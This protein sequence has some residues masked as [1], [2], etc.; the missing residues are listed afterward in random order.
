[1]ATRYHNVSIDYPSRIIDVPKSRFIT[2]DK[3][4]AKVI[5]IE[6]IFICPIDKSK[7][8]CYNTEVTKSL[9]Q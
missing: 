1:M 6:K 9:V 4:T 5:K 7:K 3:K 2:R 8:L